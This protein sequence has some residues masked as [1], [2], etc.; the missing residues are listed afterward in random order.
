M[1]AHLSLKHIHQRLAT[2]LRFIQRS[3]IT[4]QKLCTALIRHLVL[5]LRLLLSRWQILCEKQWRRVSFSYLG[6][7]KPKIDEDSGSTINDDGQSQVSGCWNSCK[8]YTLLI[9]SSSFPSK[10]WHAL[11][12]L[13]SLNRTMVQVQVLH[14]HWT[15]SC[16]VPKC[17]PQVVIEIH[18]HSIDLCLTILIHQYM[19][20]NSVLYRPRPLIHVALITV[21][22]VTVLIRRNLL[23]ALVPE[24]SPDCHAI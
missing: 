3:G 7:T 21:Y 15:Q 5:S 11:S 14:K 2:F 4:S 23:I 1:L 19:L 24:K 18:P 9:S 17:C 12:I 16:K 13:P 10:T 8:V 6:L 22:E 20:R